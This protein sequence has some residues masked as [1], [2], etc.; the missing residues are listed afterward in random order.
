MITMVLQYK[1]WG[2]N[3]QIIKLKNSLHFG[4]KHMETGIQ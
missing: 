3:I 4:I 1:K 2:K